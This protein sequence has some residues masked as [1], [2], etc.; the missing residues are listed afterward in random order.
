MTAQRDPTAHRKQ[1]LG[2]RSASGVLRLLAL[3]AGPSRSWVLTL[4]ACALS[5][6]AAVPGAWAQVP[7]LPA[8]ST[9]TTA[10]RVS[11]Q[12]G[13]GVTVDGGEA[14][15]LNLRGRMQLRDT[16]TALPSAQNEIQI[17]TMRLWL[18]GHQ[19]SRNIR[20]G[21]QLAFGGNDFETGSASPLFDAFVDFT[22]L[23]DLNVRVGQFFVPF[24]RARTI[25]EFALS[26][27][28]RP[29]VV[30]E[31][32]L[33]RD[34]GV[35]VS[36]QDLFGLGG[37]LAYNLGVF[38]GEGRN[39]F[40]GGQPGFL[41]TARVAVRPFGGFDEDMEGDLEQ[42]A[43]PKWM[44]GVATA[45][46]QNAQRQRGTTGTTYALGSVDYW[47]AA[48]DTVL[49]W[50]GLSVMAEAVMRQSPQQ[51]HTGKDTAGVALTEY[52][53]RGVG[54]LLQAGYLVH[55]R[56]EAW[57]RWDEMLLPWATDPALH[58]TV[59]ATG[60]AIAAGV[61]YYLNGHLFKIQADAVHQFGSA[62]DSGRTVVRLQVDVTF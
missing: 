2:S 17:R 29:A 41:Y 1:P 33:D 53:R 19:L 9:G 15:A 14:Y 56:V 35:A 6:G 47:W 18:T 24:D 42:H 50:R 60:K 31:F 5:V 21:V 40:G 37:R 22:H 38:G 16:V 25:R 48:V 32:T 36:S 28:D 34:V 51:V 45:Y 59:A 4:A 52:T 12:P 3:P 58:K 44:L 43:D 8:D 54:Y 61:N 27:V 23:R 20:Y 46:N 10:V 57:A 49:K 30:P 26:A 13:K 62:L 39:R 7:A 11:V 55:P